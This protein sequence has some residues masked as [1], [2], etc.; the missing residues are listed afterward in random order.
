V[1]LFTGHMIDL[2]GRPT[3]R[4]PS[5]CERAAHDAIHAAL[6]EEVDRT[7]GSVVGIAS[8]ANGGDILFHEVCAELGIASRLLLP[9]PPD[10][11]RNE[12]VLPA[13]VAWTRRF[14]SLMQ[15]FPSPPCLAKA[16]ELPV[17]LW[18]RA[19]YD[20]WERANLWLINEA[21]AVGA[22]QFTLLALW[23]GTPGDGPGGT[24]HMIRI[25]KDNG[26][27]TIVLSTHAVFASCLRAGIQAPSE[28]ARS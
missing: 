17:W 7:S 5:V 1:V 21:L 22:P 13:G 28:I 8:G 10:L 12:S 9:L 14:D 16:D 15:R 3:A 6:K 25:A 20:T 24:E 27:T 19:H 11:F 23:D 18:T 2:P 26:A 4:F